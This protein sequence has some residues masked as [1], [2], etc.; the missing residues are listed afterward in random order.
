MQGIVD[1]KAGGSFSMNY[2]NYNSKFLN[3]ASVNGQIILNDGAVLS[4]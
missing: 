3:G 1:I 4:I 2:D